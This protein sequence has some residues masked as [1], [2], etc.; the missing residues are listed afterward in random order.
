MKQWNSYKTQISFQEYDMIIIGSGIG[1]LCA[2]ALLRLQGKNVLVLE[3]HFK[4][5]GWTHT[6]KRKN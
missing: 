1:S 2:A 4:I 3:K 5:G 6:F